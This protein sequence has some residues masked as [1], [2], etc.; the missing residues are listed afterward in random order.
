MGRRIQP[1]VS[2]SL[3]MSVNR[4]ISELQRMRTEQH[5]IESHHNFPEKSTLISGFA[6]PQNKLSVKNDINYSYYLGSVVI[7][8]I[9]ETKN[10]GVCNSINSGNDEDVN[11]SQLCYMSNDIRI[12]AHSD[13]LLKL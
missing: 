11:E 4:Q 13:G 7:H 10:D 1:L 5:S 6:P 12:S 9:G 8:L 2:Q 3:G